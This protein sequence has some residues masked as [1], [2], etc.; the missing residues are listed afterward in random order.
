MS[1]ISILLF[2]DGAAVLAVLSLKSENILMGYS[3]MVVQWVLIPLVRVQLTV[4][5]LRR[6]G[7]IGRRTRLRI[8]RYNRASSN[9]VTC[10][11]VP[12]SN[13]RTQPFQGC[14]AGFDSRWNHLVEK[15]NQSLMEELL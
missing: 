9:L 3:I 7:G 12:L 14:S 13:G 10:S 2:G 1:D 4:A 6:C 11:M 8:W 15:S 5:Q